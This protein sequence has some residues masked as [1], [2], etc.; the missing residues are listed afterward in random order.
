MRIS[1]RHIIISALALM[2]LPLVLPASATG[3]KPLKAPETL[4]KIAPQIPSAD[5]NNS[6]RV[7]LE[8]ADVMKQMERDS[9]IIVTGNV[10][11]SHG[12]MH[13]FCDSAHFYDGTESLDAFGNIRMEQGDTLFIYGD[14]LTFNG[15][16]QKAYLYGTDARPVKMI[17]RDVTLLTPTFI[18]DLRNEYGYY[19]E[20]GTL[21][22]KGNRLIS[23]EGE[24]IPKTKEANFYDNVHLTSLSKSDT[25]EI[26]SD[27]LFYNTESHIAELVSPSTIINAQ[28]TITTDN[29]TYDTN[30]SV[31]NLYNRSKVVASTGTT[32]EGDTLFYDRNVGFGEAFGNMEIVD[33]AHC[34]ILTGNY[35]YYNELTDSA[36][37]TG[38]AL[39]KEYSQGDTLY[40]HGRYLYSFT[41]TDTTKFEADTIAGIEAYSIV[42]TTH[43]MVAHPRVRF[44]RSDM[45]GLCD[46]LRFEERDSTLF[47]F[48]HPVVWSDE[49]QIF[50]NIIEVHLNDST[51]DKAILP[52]FAFS[53]ERIEGN[54]FNQLSGKEMI[55]YFRDSELY[56]LDVNGNVQAI[57]LP[58]ENDSTY[59]KIVNVE[60][61]FMTAD[62]EGR[63]I[64]KMKMWP[65][66]NG[67]VTPLYLAKKSLFFLPQFKWY[68]DMRP[69]SPEDVFLVPEQM[70]TLMAD[71][72]Q[73]PV[74]LPGTLLERIARYSAEEDAAE[75]ETEAEKPNTADEQ[76]EPD[77]ENPETA[78]SE[79]EAAAGDESLE[80]EDIPDE[81][82]G[83]AEGDQSEM[84][85]PL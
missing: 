38:R 21:T 64:L 49:R 78:A 65:S 73:Y 35:G 63:D 77:K 39:A 9:F 32:L 30:T 29:G 57:M 7:F 43:V 11:F 16:E 82:Q 71:I 58:M 34:V 79:S 36:F 2:A 13:M 68:T 12:A 54:F 55:A 22:D 23:I 70:E 40:M 8:R 24:Y 52:D 26:L 48:H 51:I 28:A 10:E 74:P 81:E 66:T 72:P 50:G 20:G 85:N 3:Q 62:F 15:L 46:S 1:A 47:M 6:K 53:A 83:E 41:V 14:E 42:D 61:S 60:S 56:R 75:E 80:P 44:Y 4:P 27:T 18:Y 25:L 67:T 5:R 37:A 59:N 69:T 33:T 84:D 17:N 45:Q 76:S 19:Y 31:A